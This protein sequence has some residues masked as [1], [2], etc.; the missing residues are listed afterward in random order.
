VGVLM[1]CIVWKRCTGDGRAD[2]RLTGQEISDGG[3]SGLSED[4]FS[5]QVLS[6]RLLVRGVFRKIARCGL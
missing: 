4:D 6:E 5:P 1:C 3:A 2:L